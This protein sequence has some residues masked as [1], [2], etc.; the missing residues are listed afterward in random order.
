MRLSP[1][2]AGVLRK[3][4]VVHDGACCDDE[5]T[6]EFFRNLKHKVGGDRRDQRVAIREAG[7]ADEAEAAEWGRS[8]VCQ[9]TRSTELE[10]LRKLRGARPDLT[11]RTA[12]YILHQVR[13]R[14]SSTDP[15][16]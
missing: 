4:L 3:G 5:M 8:V 15:S 13:T 6:I 2:P 16:T 14:S 1:K 11:L 12:T 7:F 10:D 9:P